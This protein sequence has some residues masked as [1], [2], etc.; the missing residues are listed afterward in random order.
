MMD[1]RNAYVELVNNARQVETDYVTVVL[2][3]KPGVSDAE[4]SRLCSA[5][6]QASG[7][8]A[9]AYPRYGG[10]YTFRNGPILM[11]NVD[12][13]ANWGMSLKNPDQLEPSALISAVEAAIARARQ[14]SAEAAER[15]RGLTG[16]IAAF[17]RWPSH[18]REAAGPGHAQRT[19]AGF[20]GFLGQLAVAVLAS[21]L[22]VW[23]AAGLVAMWGAAF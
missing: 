8:A 18:L 19:A 5:T 7:A 4:W 15:E 21:V 14:A 2:A 20:I 16:L 23:V 22:A 10:K 3:P 13:V 1:F 9:E 12:P 17:L 11:N 6:A